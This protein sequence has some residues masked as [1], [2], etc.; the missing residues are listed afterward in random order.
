MCVCV[1]VSLATQEAVW[2]RCLVEEM[3][4]PDLEAT[5]IYEDNQGAIATAHNPVFHR[6]TK[7]IRFHS[8]NF[9]ENMNMCTPF[10]RHSVPVPLTTRGLP[11]L[12]IYSLFIQHFMSS[13]IR[14]ICVYWIYM[15][16]LTCKMG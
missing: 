3:G 10:S 7:H 5:V 4:N 9:L 14:C 8:S 16:I 12:L 13:F 6:R 2:L 15:V 11:K 1:C